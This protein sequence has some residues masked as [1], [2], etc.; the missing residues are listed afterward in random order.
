MP[1]KIIPETKIDDEWSKFMNRMNKNDDDEDSC[2]DDD[3][4]EIET[5][6]LFEGSSAFTNNIQQRSCEKPQITKRTCIS[7]KQQRK[8][9]SF[10]DDDFGST[11]DTTTTTA[12][13]APAAPPPSFTS[14]TDASIPKSSS[15]YISTK[16]KIAYLNKGVDIYNVLGYT[17]RPLLYTSRIR[18]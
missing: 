13:A 10:V 1:P 12:G 17:H 15:I 8:T 4:I 18:Y 14:S 6:N 16:T 11:I 3:D 7:K 9:Y 2:G 5:T